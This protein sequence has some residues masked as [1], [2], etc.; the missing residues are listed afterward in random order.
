MKGSGENVVF[1]SDV[2]NCFFSKSFICQFLQRAIVADI[3]DTGW[4]GGAFDRDSNCEKCD[5]TRPKLLHT[6][7][8]C[9]GVIDTLISLLEIKLNELTFKHGSRMI[10]RQIAHTSLST[11]H[12][13]RQTWF[14]FLTLKMSSSSKIGH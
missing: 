3:T 4:S 7:Y 9:S 10:I 2:K 1:Y 13:H 6:H 12:C 5:Y 11:S 8:S 14:H